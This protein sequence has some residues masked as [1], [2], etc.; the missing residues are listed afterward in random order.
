[1]KKTSLKHKVA[2]F[3]LCMLVTVIGFSQSA[4]S[5]A[6]QSL[7]STY[8][9]LEDSSQIY[10][11]AND[12]YRYYMVWKQQLAILDKMRI[13]ID[14]VQLENSQP[15]TQPKYTSQNQ[16]YIVLDT[17]KDSRPPLFQRP[18]R[19]A[20][21]IRL[22]YKPDKYRGAKYMTKNWYLELYKKK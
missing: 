17:L 12:T 14:Y 20:K 1:M 7:D 22:G 9:A 10:K 16:Q 8:K 2:V 11:K 13:V 5:K 19:Y 6:Y 3:L 21:L 4:A 18:Y 15:D